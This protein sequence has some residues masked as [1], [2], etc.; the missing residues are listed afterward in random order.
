[1]GCVIQVVG[2]PRRLGKNVF[3]PKFSTIMPSH[4]TLGHN[5]NCLVTKGYIWSQTGNSWSQ[6][7]THPGAQELRLDGG[8]ESAGAAADDEHALAG[9]RAAAL[10]HL[11]ARALVE[12]KTI[13]RF[14]INF[15][16]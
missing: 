3:K 4:S 1:M 12:L 11:V 8:P 16:A 10:V 9:A 2:R 5:I 14:K 15:M 6:L 7:A 13:L